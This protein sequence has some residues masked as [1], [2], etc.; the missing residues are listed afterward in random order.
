MKVF[1]PFSR[2]FWP[3]M[4]MVSGSMRS[5]TTILQRVLATSSDS[6]GC[7]PEFNAPYFAFSSGMKRLSGK[8]RIREN[9]R[10]HTVSFWKLQGRPKLLIAKDPMIAAH[11]DHFVALTP[12]IRHV[13]SVRDPRD[14]LQSVLTVH[15]KMLAE[16]NPEINIISRLNEI[17]IVDYVMGIYRSV[18]AVE[19]SPNVMISRYE[20]LVV[21]D[22][23]LR[24][25]LSRFIGSEIHYAPQELAPRQPHPDDRYFA[26]PVA[27]KEISSS[28]IGGGRCL[29]PTIE[30]ELL[31]HSDVFEHFGYSNVP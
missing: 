4:V 18:W 3:N 25:K 20:S 11:I 15:Q 14:V 17:G 6:N 31:R 24:R 23:D 29:P 16:E 10:K 2:S 21:K 27:G 30:R 7:S 19:D 8:K 12:T 28:R 13:I 1:R 26:T 9:I 5:G 22:E